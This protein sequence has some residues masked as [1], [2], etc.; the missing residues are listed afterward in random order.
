MINVHIEFFGPLS[1]AEKQKLH[2]VVTRCPIHKLMT[3]TTIEIVTAPFVSSTPV[4]PAT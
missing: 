4:A 1:E 3:T 2:D